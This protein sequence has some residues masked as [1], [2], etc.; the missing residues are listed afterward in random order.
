MEPGEPSRIT[1][2][3]SRLRATPRMRRW[4]LCWQVHAPLH[5]MEPAAQGVTARC[6]RATVPGKAVHLRFALLRAHA[7]TR[8]I[9]GVACVW[10]RPSLWR[11]G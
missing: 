9:G 10:L 1:R 8:T 11:L 4:N 7:A 5:L 2:D 3:M 6:I